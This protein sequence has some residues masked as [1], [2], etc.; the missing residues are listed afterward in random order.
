MLVI[1]NGIA[2]ATAAD[3]VRRRHPHCEIHLIGRERHH[4]YNRMGI[5]RLI[6]GHSAMEGIYLLPE[7]WYNDNQITCWLN[8]HVTSLDAEA[9][10][11][12]CMD[13]LA[14]WTA[15]LGLH[16]ICSRQ[17]QFYRSNSD[18]YSSILKELKK[19]LW[20]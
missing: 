20:P 16:R 3:H 6:Y 13:C 10:I 1:G 17:T 7:K 12:L 4:L 2:G 15:R 14:G 9:Q 8:T 11:V 5:T 18:S 19:M